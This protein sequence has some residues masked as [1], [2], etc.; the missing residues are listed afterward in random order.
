ME[1]LCAPFPGGGRNLDGPP[2]PRGNCW[3]QT[4]VAALGLELPVGLAASVREERRSVHL[5]GHDL[6]P[7]GPRRGA[8]GGEADGRTSPT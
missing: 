6:G 5:E 1:P 4:C 8:G 2:F 7:T 3:R